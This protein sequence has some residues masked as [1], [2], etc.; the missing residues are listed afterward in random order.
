VIQLS[1]CACS[2][3]DK[4]LGKIAHIEEREF[5]AGGAPT[6]YLSLLAVSRPDL[7]RFF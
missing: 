5:E 3:A 7:A 6:L 4:C 1:N 2:P